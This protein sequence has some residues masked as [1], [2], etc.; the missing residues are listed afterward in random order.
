MNK[1]YSLNDSQTDPEK[2]RIRESK[3]V[4]TSEVPEVSKEQMA[5]AKIRYNKIPLSKKKVRV[6]ILLDETI[7]AYFKSLAGG[8]GYQTLIND[9]LKQSMLQD[10]LENTLRRIIRE[11]LKSTD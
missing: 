5:N 1:N 8:R 3:E 9:A 10:N 7:V 6:N 4:N 11:E 2:L